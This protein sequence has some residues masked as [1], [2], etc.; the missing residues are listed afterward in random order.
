ML[1]PRRLTEDMVLMEEAVR[2]ARELKASLGD[3]CDDIA[4]LL[5]PSASVEAAPLVS[6]P[7]DLGP[8]VEPKLSAAAI[9]MIS[10]T[11]AAVEQVVR[12][13]RN[14]S[15]AGWVF[16]DEFDAA[17]AGSRR[18]LVLEHPEAG[19]LFAD[20]GPPVERLDVAEA[21]P[22]ADPRFTSRSGFSVRLL[23]A[24]LPPGA[25]RLGFV[26]ANPQGARFLKIPTLLTLG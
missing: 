14:P 15:L 8:L 7:P 19:R 23:T 5:A 13:T 6:T 24:S 11:P 26:L 25:Y 4:E 2:R 21:Y 3:H 17:E 22:Q 12:R 18:Y 16:A 20:L 1:Q 9:D 10:G